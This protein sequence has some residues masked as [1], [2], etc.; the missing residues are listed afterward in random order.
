MIHCILSIFL[1]LLAIELGL[2]AI[3][4]AWT[5]LCVLLR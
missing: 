5:L 3:H 2:L 1:W 4:A